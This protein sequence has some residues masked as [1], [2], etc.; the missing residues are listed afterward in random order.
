MFVIKLFFLRSTQFFCLVQKEDSSH[1]WPLPKW[2][3][4]RIPWYRPTWGSNKSS[5]SRAELCK[6]K[7]HVATS[8]LFSTFLFLPSLFLV[9]APFYLLCRPLCCLNESSPASP[10]LSQT[11]LRALPSEQVIQYVS[12]IPWLSISPQG[13][14]PASVQVSWTHRIRADKEGDFLNLYYLCP[15]THSSL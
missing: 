9:T 5:D 2:Q 10:L 7:S 8:L 6:L 4:D 15:S 1:S 11:L 13:C 14:G 3:M 12:W